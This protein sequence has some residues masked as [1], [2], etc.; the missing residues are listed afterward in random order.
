MGGNRT[1]IVSLKDAVIYVRAFKFARRIRVTYKD[2]IV[3]YKAR[4]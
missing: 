3:V 1:V 4:R 2:G